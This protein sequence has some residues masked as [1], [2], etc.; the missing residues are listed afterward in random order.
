MKFGER[1]LTILLLAAL[2]QTIPHHLTICI[3]DENS[4][5]RIGR[6]W[7]R[8]GRRWGCEGKWEKRE[9]V[10]CY[11]YKTGYYMGSPLALTIFS[12]WQAE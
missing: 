8:M 5:E 3:C 7:G 9:A 11:C 6:E 2:R 12:A 10:H 1:A 4:G